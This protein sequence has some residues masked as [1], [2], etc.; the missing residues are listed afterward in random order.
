MTDSRHVSRFV[1]EELHA[2]ALD[3]PGGTLR[4][5][6]EACPRCRERLDALEP[7]DARF[8][9]RFPTEAALRRRRPA[10]AARSRRLWPA[11]AFG[12]ALAAAAGVVLVLS[13]PARHPASPT[14]P[15]ERVKGQS[16]MEIAVSR[17]DSSF[18]Y[19]A[20]PLRSGDVLVFSYSSDR[21]FLLLLGLEGSGKARVLLP[22]DARAS[23]PIARG[24]RIRLQHGIELDDYPGPER[25]IALFSDDPLSAETVIA[26]VQRRHASLEGA[27]RSH[28]VLGR[29]PFATDE[30]SWLLRKERP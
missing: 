26:E 25:L 22:P 21:S 12:S 10:S 20:Q 29:L 8:L 11:A 23:M 19:D 7:A 6:V 30:V 17:A 5:H 14:A 24:A 13:Q 16:I 9:E 1:L 2:G 15:T 3:D 28:L 18:Q 27:A 4:A